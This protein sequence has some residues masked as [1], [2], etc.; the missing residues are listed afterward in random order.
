[1]S[2]PVGGEVIR[3]RAEEATVARGIDGLPVDFG[4]F[5]YNASF[6]IDFVKNRGV[7]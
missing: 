4:E 6:C 1:M 3:V 5:F 7:S 2:S